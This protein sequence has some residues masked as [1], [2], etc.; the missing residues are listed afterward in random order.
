ME[1]GTFS[2]IP[3]SWAESLLRIGTSVLLPLL[4]GI[5][6]FVHRKPIDFRPLMIVSRGACALSLTIMELRSR[7]KCYVR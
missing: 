5:D 2:P 4:I 1:P 3:I 6:R 7:T